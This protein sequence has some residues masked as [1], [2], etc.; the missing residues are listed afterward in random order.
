MYV[1]DTYSMC[2]CLLLSGDAYR[3]GDWVPLHHSPQIVRNMM[4][5]G[6]YSAGDSVSES[7]SPAAGF[8]SAGSSWGNCFFSSVSAF[9]AALFSWCR[10][11]EGRS[12]FPPLTFSFFTAGVVDMMK[13]KMLL[14][15]LFLFFHTN[16][17]IDCSNHKSYFNKKHVCSSP[18]PYS[19]SNNCESSI[20]K[21]TL[22]IHT[23][24]KF[25]LHRI[26]LN[27][28]LHNRFFLRVR[29]LQKHSGWLCIGRQAFIKDRLWSIAFGAQGANA[30]IGIV[31]W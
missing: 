9:L 17:S 25:P 19:N 8:S 12:L 11:L 10:C 16:R 20:E 28:T 24:Y 14:A 27:C 2:F 21:L 22:R 26:L 1:C 30:C 13:D 31:F 3:I 18:K 5:L 6:I 4:T 7:E 29:P 23:P 15:R